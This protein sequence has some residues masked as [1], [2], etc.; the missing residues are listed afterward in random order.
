MPTTDLR[1]PGPR[2]P[3]LLVDPAVVLKGGCPEPRHDRL[4]ALSPN[5]NL[6]WRRTPPGQRTLLSRWCGRRAYRP[7]RATR[8]G[9]P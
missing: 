7:R 4:T 8:S 9:G 2:D 6:P 3:G 5:L 1:I